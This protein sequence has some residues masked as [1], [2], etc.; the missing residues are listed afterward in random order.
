M[1]KEYN[2]SIINHIYASINDAEQSLAAAL[3][4]ADDRRFFDLHPEHDDP[5]TV[6]GGE[7]VP[8]VKRHKI[9]QRITRSTEEL[10]RLCLAF[11]GPQGASERDVNDLNALAVEARIIVDTIEACPE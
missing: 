7:I 10:D 9:E 3:V 4:R 6:P 2:Q 11:A 5:S 8:Y 1:N